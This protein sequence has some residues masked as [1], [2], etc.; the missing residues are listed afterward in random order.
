MQAVAQVVSQALASATPSR[1]WHLVL[2]YF[3][4]AM[5]V[6]LVAIVLMVSP[7]LAQEAAS[8]AE[9]A[10][11][12]EPVNLAPI[13]AGIAILGIIGPGIGIGILG[14]MSAS[15]IGRNPDAAADIRGLAIILAAFAE[16]LGVLG[17]VVGFLLA[18]GIGA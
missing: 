8:S 14:G 4:V 12:G 18:L 5:A 7:T 15:A 13:G 17:I 2:V 9:A 16:G 1:R 11:A 6:S 3:A 10:T